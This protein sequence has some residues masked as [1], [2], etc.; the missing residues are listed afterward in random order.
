MFFVCGIN[1]RNKGGEKATHHPKR[2]KAKQVSFSS[3][4][5]VKQ[6]PISYPRNYCIRTYYTPPESPSHK[7]QF[8][9]FVCVCGLDLSDASRQRR[10]Q[11]SASLK[12]PGDGVP[13]MV[14]IQVR[15]ESVNLTIIPELGRLENQSG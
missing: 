15:S 3:N 6:R 13:K 11:F 9:V 1:L 5:D 10:E 2:E 8:R 7:L 12:T 14:G 4:N